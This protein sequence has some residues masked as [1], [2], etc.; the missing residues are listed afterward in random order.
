MPTAGNVSPNVRTLPGRPSSSRHGLGAAAATLL[1]CA[2]SANAAPDAVLRC[3]FHYMGDDKTLTF[4]ITAD[5]YRA[6]VIPVSRSFLFKAVVTG[7]DD[8]IASVGLYAYYLDR[9]KPI[10]LQASRHVAPVVTDGSDPSALTGEQR[11][12][13]PNLERELIY[14]CALVRSQP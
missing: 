10:L 8:G 5:P 14:G 4:G 2:S 9:D 7:C 12:Y 3:A 13:S 1:L 6:P 11:L